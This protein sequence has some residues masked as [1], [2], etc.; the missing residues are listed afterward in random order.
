MANKYWVG[1]TGTWNNSTTTNWSDT[2]GGSG[3]ATVPTS[4]DD[5]FIDS[6]SG[7]GVITITS[8]AACNNCTVTWTAAKTNT[9]TLSADFSPSGTLSIQGNSAVNR[10]LVSSTVIGTARVITATL[11]TMSNVDF[12]DITGAGAGS[13]N[14]SSISGGSGDCGGN[15]GI[16]FTSPTTQTAT[17]STNK[18][19]DDVTIWTSRVPLPQDNVSLASV[20]GGQL[21]TNGMPR[22]GKDIDWTGATG[23]PTFA[24]NIS[25]PTIYGSLT[26]ISGMSYSSSNTWNLNGRGTHTI[27]TAGKTIGGPISMSAFG[28]TYTLMDALTT[29]GAITISNGTFDTANFNVTSSSFVSSGTSTRA[30]TLGTS[31]WSITATSASTVW[32]GGFATGMTLSASSSTIS[33]STTSANTRTFSGAGLTYGTLTYTISGSTGGLD[34]TGANSFA[35]IN[36]SDASNTRTLRFTASTTT[37]IRESNG[38]NVRGTSGKLMNVSSITAATHTLTSTLQQSTDYLNLTNSI[39]T[40]GGAWYAGANA[41]DSGGN[42]GWI[43]TAAPA[44]G[45]NGSSPGLRARNNL[46]NLQSLH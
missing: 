14:L 23:S 27:T 30:L 16:T 18:N 6:S 46:Q 38:F 24:P 44:A 22:L 31:T 43:F 34:I 37:T 39:A 28:G 40:G 2:S 3:G 17:M 19:W 13:W 5:V 21:A 8:T 35:Y 4:A 45:T 9:L 15:S 25:N 42:T 26:F 11:G 29:T 33:I 20:T 36:F 1:G 12:Q 41:T 10:I 32:N 7:T